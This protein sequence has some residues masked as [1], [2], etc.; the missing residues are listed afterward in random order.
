MA[1][2]VA[3][4]LTNAGCTVVVQD[5]DIPLTANFI[6]AMH[7]AIKS[8][9]DLIV[10][11][12][13]DY[14]ASPY[15]RSEFTSFEAD[16]A[17]SLEE[18]RMVIL[19]CDDTPLRGLFA[20][21]VSQNLYGI[22]DP[23][24]RKR[25]ILAAAQG[26]SQA[27]KPPPRPFVGVPPR[28]PSFTGRDAEFARLDAI[29]IGGRPAAV[30]QAVGTAV[31]QIGRAAV[32]GMGGVG[33]TALAVEYAFRYR[34]LYA[35]VWWCPAE[36]RL[37]LQT[38]L[39]ELAKALG[40]ALG[41]EADVEQ[42]AKAG[43]RRLAEQRAIFLL[44][45]DNVAS[46]DDVA[47]LLPASG[48]R[49]LVTSRFGD[50]SDWAEEVALDVLPG[51][52]A[53]A[54]LEGRAGRLDKEGAATLAEA[55][56]RLP[57]ALDHAAAYCKRTQNSFLAYEA[58]AARLIAAAPRGV[59][60]PRSVAA[61]F[62]L[63]IDEATK[64]CAAAEPLMAYLA[65]CAPERIPMSLVEGAIADE[66]EREAGLLALNEVS[67]LKHDPFEDGTPAVTVHRLV[68]ATARARSETNGSA[69][70][71]AQRIE[72]RLTAIYPANDLRD[73]ASWVVC[74]QLTPHLL[75]CIAATVGG[76][77]TETQ[78]ELLARA[79]SYFFGRGAYSRARP[80]LETA[81]LIREKKLGA[82]HPSTLSSLNN[83]GRAL[84]D[85]A[86][87][88]LA[89]PLLERVLA[90]HEKV[91]G[92]EHHETAGALNNLA[93]LLQAQGDHS[94]ARALSERALTVYEKAVG[95][96]HSDTARSLNNLALLLKDEGDLASARPLLERA[97]EI[98]QKVLGLEHRDTATSI[99]N[100]AHLLLAEGD[101]AGARPLF[102]R[103]LVIHES[104]L[105]PE[106]LSTAGLL[107][108]FSNL[109]NH[110]GDVAGA[111]LLIE[112]ALAIHEKMTWSR[113]SS[114]SGEPRGFC[115]PVTRAGRFCTSPASP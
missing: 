70:A 40:T 90:L 49:V 100:L 46:P 56:G 59:N 92:P 44:V 71:A 26:Q 36:T 10:L 64:Q 83:L 23:E 30:T 37:G 112:R 51:T 21:N 94:R 68:Q 58:K 109:L 97:L 33:K 78:A 2:E 75:L 114:H 105:G 80:L 53:V 82:E 86:E 76:T 67:L 15:T 41:E 18:R 17:R 20:P 48:A 45:Y 39:A 27:Q 113:A 69:E 79:G 102:E 50:W 42:A 61:T 9:R 87:F 110:Q 96:E 111:R 88:A 5:Y 32:Q 57:L 63:A 16:R 93:G 108:N 95:P 11:H 29:L 85:Q 101:L 103:A 1:Q 99:G 66:I 84:H 89:R 81:L 72:L 34:D 24:E 98:R 13:E 19:C 74:A 14:E 55:L 28:I 47:D 107:H 31:E 3:N 77:G 4:V 60:Y 22:Q 54:F 62:D 12:T 25:R 104:A 91:H 8:A 38:A 52:E 73:P 115:P 7:E 106:H 65:Q 43:L 35:G 6:E